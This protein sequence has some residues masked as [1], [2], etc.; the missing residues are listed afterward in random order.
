MHF[1]TPKS[2]KFS[3]LLAPRKGCTAMSRKEHHAGPRGWR[4][5]KNHVAERRP[6][7]EICN[8]GCDPS[9][10]L[11]EVWFFSKRNSYY[12]MTH[13][14]GEKKRS[15][16]EVVSE[17][18]VPLLL[19]L[20]LLLSKSKFLVHL[21]FF[22]NKSDRKFSHLK[23][24]QKLGGT[25]KSPSSEKLFYENIAQKMLCRRHDYRV[26]TIPRTGTRAGQLRFPKAKNSKFFRFY[27]WIQNDPICRV[28]S[29]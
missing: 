25:S 5:R 15:W 27:D 10:G 8:R 18:C 19:L 2:Q 22:P 24:H 4:G 13:N 11:L 23:Q 21:S 9:L 26:L 1:W 17:P 3:R 28:E 20:V 16:Y 12:Y 6:K 7:P 29:F 14:A